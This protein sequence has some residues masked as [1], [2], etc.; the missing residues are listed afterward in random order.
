[1]NRQYDELAAKMDRLQ[2]SVD[3]LRGEFYSTRLWLF[4]T[5]LGLAAIFIEIALRT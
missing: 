4:T 5:W 1:M 2:E 3:R